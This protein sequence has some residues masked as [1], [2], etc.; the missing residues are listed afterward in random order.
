ML[1]SAPT[2]IK[3]PEGPG[4]EFRWPSRHPSKGN[5]CQ[6]IYNEGSDT[7]TMKFR[8]VSRTKDKDIASL[9]DVYFDQL[10]PIF[11]ERT[12]WYLRV[13]RIRMA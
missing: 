1:G 4:I 9:D 3:T 10:V 12:G 2:V 11:E 7:Y 5:T 13:P 8:Y 6:V